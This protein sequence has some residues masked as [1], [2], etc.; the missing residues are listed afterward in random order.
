MAQLKLSPDLGTAAANTLI[1]QLVELGDTSVSLDGSEVRTLGGR[2]LEV[3]L[4]ARAIWAER[5]LTLTLED[6]SPPL[7]SALALCGALE[8]GLLE[9]TLP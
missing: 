1:D 2:S 8:C 3:L 9:D 7:L 5:G 6:A 4:S